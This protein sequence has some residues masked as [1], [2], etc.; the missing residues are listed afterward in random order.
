MLWLMLF[1][2]MAM[3]SAC[4]GGSS[5]GSDGG[6]GDV[7]GVQALTYAGSEDPAVMDGTNIEELIRGAM[8]LNLVESGVT[9]KAIL[10]SALSRSLSV[11]GLTPADDEALSS[12][13][14][15]R[16]LSDGMTR[17]AV[18]ATVGYAMQDFLSYVLPEELYDRLI[19]ADFPNG[20]G[21]ATFGAWAYDA[22]TGRYTIVITLDQAEHCSEAGS[23]GCID[24]FSATGTVTVSMAFDAEP[25]APESLAALM[26][27]LEW[28]E[29]DDQLIA[30]SGRFSGSDV[31]AGMTM[32]V[33]GT[34]E[35]RFFYRADDTSMERRYEGTLFGEM[36]FNNDALDIMATNC[37]IMTAS[38]EIADDE[39]GTESVYS[40][41]NI[42]GGLH[43]A[44][45]QS[46]GSDGGSR[47]LTVDLT[48]GYLQAEEEQTFA[49]VAFHGGKTGESGKSSSFSCSGDVTVVSK[50]VVGE[51]ETEIFNLDLELGTLAYA[52]EYGN[53]IDGDNRVR[54]SLTSIELQASLSFSS[55][56]SAFMVDDLD[57]FFTTS[58]S[59]TDYYT[60][61]GENDGYASSS[62]VEAALSGELSVMEEGEQVF[63]IQ[64][65]MLDG[66]PN[67][68]L[69]VENG[70][71]KI[72]GVPTSENSMALHVGR[73]AIIDQGAV[74]TYGGNFTLTQTKAGAQAA[75]SLIATDPA[76]VTT[77]MDDYLIDAVYGGEGTVVNIDGTFYHSVYGYVSVDT[78]GTAF[79]FVDGGW[80]V[81]GAL[82]VTASNGAVGRLE[83]MDGQYR[84]QGDMNGDGDFEDEGDFIGAPVDWPV[85]PWDMVMGLLSTGIVK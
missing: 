81:D 62:R 77:F 73:L 5:G 74:Y 51:I 13:S 71:A 30:V 43:L 39:A 60:E 85:A 31:A 54:T 84:I 76:G 6:A 59:A 58:E 67:M 4:G 20:G 34:L 15:V 72:D 41:T 35:N 7:D 28:G 66:E 56:G 44:L 83:A 47:V 25:E 42:S 12:P 49:V 29:S 64:A 2:A 22:T 26:A 82:T 1:A 78:T 40:D 46:G 75:L 27:L 16:S 17:S 45:T 23:T 48:N 32:A 61:T 38:G 55:G 53:R 19:E 11:S 80:P 57:F 52:T 33:S 10:P 68:T 24:S 9:A 21:T 3:L 69:L 8:G 37:M 14:I 36:T 79:V 50:Y 18:G 70:Y 65:P 63:A